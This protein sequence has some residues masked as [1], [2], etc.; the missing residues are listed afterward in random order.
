MSLKDQLTPAESKAMQELEALLKIKREDALRKSL[1]DDQADVAVA[2]E[3][4][5]LSWTDRAPKMGKGWCP[6]I[7]R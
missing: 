3:A 5:G 4:D 6:K 7:E 2:F 1:G